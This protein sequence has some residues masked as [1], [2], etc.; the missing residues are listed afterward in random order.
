MMSQES[1]QMGKKLKDMGSV[2][3]GFKTGWQFSVKEWC[4]EMKVQKDNYLENSPETWFSAISDFWDP[5]L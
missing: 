2:E 3:A 1:L 5:E 4:F